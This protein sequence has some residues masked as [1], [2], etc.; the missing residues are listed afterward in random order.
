MCKKSITCVIIR[1]SIF[2]GDIMK[3]AKFKY[4]LKNEDQLT[5]FGGI[6]IYYE[7][8]K[9]LAFKESSGTQVFIDIEHLLLT[10]DNDDM[11][12][13]LDFN[14]GNSF[15]QMKKMNQK[16][17]LPTKINIKEIKENRFMVNYTLSEQNNFEFIIEWDL[18][19]E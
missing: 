18:G 3:K 7:D 19:G 11:T 13:V 9:I 8:R 12:L 1:V 2:G 14:M 15:I 17:N 5:E 4:H 10:R 6:C 16:M